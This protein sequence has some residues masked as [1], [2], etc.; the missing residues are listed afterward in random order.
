MEIDISKVDLWEDLWEKARRNSNSKGGVSGYQEYPVKKWNKR[1]TSY[2]KQTQGKT[3][4]R[5]WISVRNFLEKSGIDLEDIRGMKI[6]DIGAGPGNFAIPFA[7]MGANVWAL[8]PAEK[9]I[10]ILEKEMTKDKITNIQTL[11]E[12]WEDINL[13]AM[14]WKKYFDFV[15]ASMSPGIN[16]RETIQKMIEASKGYCYLSS[17]AGAREY[18]LQEKIAKE[19]LG[20][21]Y[22]TYSPNIIYP[23]NLLYAMGYLPNISFE[24]SNSQREV[25]LGDIF[26]EIIS[27]IGMYTEIDTKTE[28]RV[29]QFLLDKANDGKIIKKTQSRIGMMLW[30]V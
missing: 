20:E 13:Q 22:K 28:N 12:K 29:K 5:R 14:G 16:N 8:D 18:P 3:M 10:D 17:F 19:I 25:D 24:E 7:E 21:N 23:F 2:A 4:N 26:V 27:H 1:A 30:Q 15:F 11:T 9:M 6:L